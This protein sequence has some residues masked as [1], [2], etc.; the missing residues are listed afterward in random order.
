MLT[1]YSNLQKLATLNS[2]NITQ[3]LS[4]N[5]Y[6][7]LSRIRVEKSN[8]STILHILCKMGNNMVSLMN[9]LLDK[10]PEIIDERD[11]NGKTALHIATQYGAIQL[12]QLLLDYDCIVDCEDDFE[13]Q[14]LHY[15]NSTVISEMLIEAGA[16]ID[17][18]DCI[19]RTPLHYAF[20]KNDM[21]I[22]NLL[23]QNDADITIRDDNGK[24]PLYYKRFKW[25]YNTN[26]YKNNNNT[27]NNY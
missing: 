10:I 26:S 20:I 4:N 3:L 7:E 18:Q 2:L 5:K 6:N 25:K 9:E 11:W 15:S 22:Y 14:P 23:L 16:C 12:V 27:S 21:E 24:K 13:R 1:N 8:G 17:E 19:G